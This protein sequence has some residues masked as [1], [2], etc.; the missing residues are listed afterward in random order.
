MGLR[1]YRT[2]VGASSAPG[3][4]L[5]GSKKV[6]AVGKQADL[7]NKVNRLERQVARLKPEVIQYVHNENCNSTGV[8]WNQVTLDVTRDLITWAN[9]RDNIDGDKWHNLAIQIRIWA[10]NASISTIRLV[11]YIPTRAA[12]VWTPSTGFSAVEIPDKT[13]FKVLSDVL[14]THDI[15]QYGFQ[16]QYV[17]LGKALTYYNSDA[18]VIDRNHI[19]VAIVWETGSVASVLDIVTSYG[20]LVT[21]K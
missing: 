2:N 7:R 14:V 3:P 13:A 5:R 19:K 1:G 21:N 10:A 8:G 12:A 16:T 18:D 9:F 6:T 17:N 20:L 4:Y 11:C 15:D